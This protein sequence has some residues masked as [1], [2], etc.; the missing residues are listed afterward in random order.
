MTQEIYT[1]RRRYDDWVV[2][3][4][5]GLHTAPLCTHIASWADLSQH[6][7]HREQEDHENQCVRNHDRN[8]GQVTTA[9]AKR[10]K[11]LSQSGHW[12]GT[13]MVGMSATDCHGMPRD[14]ISM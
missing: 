9:A 10:C 3:V 11:T 5:T 13:W 12:A 1:R 14:T 8:C 7:A 6:Q 4:Y 2:S